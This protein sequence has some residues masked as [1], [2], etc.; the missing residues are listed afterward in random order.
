MKKTLLLAS[1]FVFLT[2]FSAF[3]AVN[4]AD[5]TGTIKIGM[6]DGTSVTVTADQALPAIPDGA[7]ISIISGT[8]NISTTGSSTVNVTMG[9]TSVQVSAGSAVSVS[10][11]QATGNA[12]IASTSGQVTVTNNGNIATLDSGD[13]VKV[14]V[15]SSTN[16]GTL[17]AETGSVNVRLADGSS[18]TLDSNH[19]SLDFQ[20]EAYTPPALP[21]VGTVETNV[22]TEE[23]AKDISPIKK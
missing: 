3:A 23:T 12:N 2:A 11:D 14:V 20:A 5:R 13:A 6:P 10:F 19:P 22:R 17:Q 9:R 4:V 16:Q 1:A 18:T 7:V 8:A 21:D 15:N